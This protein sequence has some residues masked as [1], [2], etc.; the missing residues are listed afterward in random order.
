M[1]MKKRL[2]KIWRYLRLDG[3]STLFTLVTLGL[4]IFSLLYNTDVSPFLFV[5]FLFMF[6]GI[7]WRGQDLDSIAELQG[8]I[9]KLIKDNNK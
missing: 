6:R 8:I 1:N 2:L 4:G 7:M 9:E 5:C 3:V